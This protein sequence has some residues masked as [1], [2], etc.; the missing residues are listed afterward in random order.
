MHIDAARIAALTSRP[1]PGVRPL[2]L[3]RDG[4]VFWVGFGLAA[5]AALE[6]I[7]D[8]DCQAPVELFVLDL[9]EPD[10]LARSLELVALIKKNLRG[11]V[12]ARL[13]FW[14]ERPRLEAAYARGVDLVEFS[15]D[16][17][18]DWDGEGGRDQLAGLAQAL[19]I[20]PRWAVVARLRWSSVPQVMAAA[21]EELLRRQI[22]PLAGLDA[23]CAP[24]DQER[25]EEVFLGLADAWRRAGVSLRPLLPL[26]EQTTPLTRRAPRSLVGNLLGRA[27]DARLRAGSDLR[28]L[29]RVRQVEQSFDSAGL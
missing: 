20:F 11:F 23:S 28:R 2:E 24:A 6:T 16:P 1:A 17:A 21:A 29:L 3:H 7:F 13:A 19:T 27:E 18:A 9:P 25:I 4:S 8:S 5:Q 15:L 10:A 12:L 26:I 22:L 14:P